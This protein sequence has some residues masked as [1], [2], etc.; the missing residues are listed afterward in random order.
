M[1][2]SLVEEEGCDIKQKDYV[3]DNSSCVSCTQWA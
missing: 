3:G 1:V 2:A